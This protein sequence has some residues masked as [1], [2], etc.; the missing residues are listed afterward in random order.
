MN[1]KKHN[2]P[3]KLSK[4]KSYLGVS[5]STGGPT[6]PVNSTGPGPT[7]GRSDYSG[8]RCRVYFSRIQSGRIGL[9]SSPQNPKKPEPTELY[10]I[11]QRDFLDPVRFQ[12]DPWNLH[13][14]WRDLVVYAQIQLQSNVFCSNKAQT[15]WKYDGFCSNPT[16]LRCYLLK[17][18]HDLVYFCSDLVSFAKIR[19]Q[20]DFFL[21]RS[22][23]FCTNPAKIQWKIQSPSKWNLRRHP[24]R[25]RPI[26]PDPLVFT[27]GG[28]LS[29]RKSDVIGSVPGWAQTR[30]GPTRGH[31]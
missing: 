1:I 28:G 7:V 18:G 27:V 13:R 19:W 26:R 3:F 17:S 22:G 31:P 4:N 5:N 15:R 6:Y 8:G 9:G 12:L 16:K 14:I 21:L 11:F 2:S 29:C 23:D 24:R 30:P 20:I 10:S 25:L